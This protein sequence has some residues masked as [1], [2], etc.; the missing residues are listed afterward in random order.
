MNKDVIVQLK[1]IV[2]IYGGHAVLKRVSFDLRA[3][4]VHCVVGE[5]GAGKSTLIKILSGAVVPEEGEIYVLGKRLR[6]LTPRLA[7]NL[8][9]STV[10]Q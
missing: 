4:E 8:G 7:I 5:N 1:N 9:I 2:K 10:Y 3:G 6:A